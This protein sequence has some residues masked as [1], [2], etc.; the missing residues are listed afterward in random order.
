MSSRLTALCVHGMDNDASWWDPVVGQL[1]TLGISPRLLVMPSLESEE[2]E[3]WVDFVLDYLTASP[4]ILIGHSLGAVV[5]FR[6]ALISHVEGVVLL[7][8]P[9]FINSVM[10]QPPPDSSLSA[11]ALA[12]VARF[13]NETC[14]LAANPVSC[15]SV[16]FVGEDDPYVPIKGAADLSFPLIPVSNAAHEL[17]NSPQF[18]PMM[19]EYIL[20]SPYGIEYLDPGIRYVNSPRTSEYTLPDLSEAAPSPARVDVEITTR[21]QLACRFCARTLYRKNTAIQ[22]MTPELF[23]TIL[24]Q[25]PHIRELFFVGLGEPL[26][27]PLIESFVTQA[28][29][30]G[31]QSKLVT[32][33]ILA[34]RRLLKKLYIKGLKEV[35]FSIDSTDPEVFR[36]LRGGASIE[37]VLEN[38]RSSPEELQTSIFVTLSQDAINLLPGIIDLASELG[39]PAVAFSDVNFAENQNRSVHQLAD[40]SRITEIIRYANTKGI[41]LITPHFHNI[42]DIPIHYGRYMVRIPA[43]IAG[44]AGQHKNCL[45]PWRTAVISA[46]GDVTPCN[47]TPQILIGTLSNQSFAELWNGDAMKKWRTSV[48]KGVCKSCLFCPRY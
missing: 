34:E 20:N 14:K 5:A 43:D 19:T 12:R 41:L 42:S 37:R 2:P 46:N 4:T 23:T 6:S 25:L 32:N 45:A 22:D 3:K 21:C 26:L 15:D 38:I 48:M 7:A 29:E 33:G 9:L 44:R 31:I 8:H 10:P 47:C 17:N 1:E 24:S 36:S 30:K 27:H 11:T 13:I 18:L 39:M 28:A 16:H 35:T 40:V